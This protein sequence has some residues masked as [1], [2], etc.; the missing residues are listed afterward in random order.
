MADSCRLVNRGRD[1]PFLPV[2]PEQASLASS[3]TIDGLG[4]GCG[5][6]T[7][8]MISSTYS[9]VASTDDQDVAFIRQG[10]SGAKCIEGM[11]G[12]SCARMGSLNLQLENGEI[13][14]PPWLR[15]PRRDIN[16]LL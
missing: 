15:L 9:C 14:V 11:E 3:N 7:Y 8:E 5:N 10:F 12:F 6:R 13:V 16:H 1:E 4:I 2:A